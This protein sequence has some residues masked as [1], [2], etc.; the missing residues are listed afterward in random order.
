MSEQI[1]IA[2]DLGTTYFRVCVNR[3]DGF[4][5]IGN[6]RKRPSC[7]ACVGGNQWVVG[8]EAKSRAHENIKNTVD[9]FSSRR[10]MGQISRDVD[11]LK[12]Q[13]SEIKYKNGKTEVILKE[14]ETT[15]YPIDVTA[16]ILHEARKMAEEYLHNVVTKAV[17]TVPAC[18]NNVLRKGTSL[19]A[20]IA[21]FEVINVINDTL[22]AATYVYE[23]RMTLPNM[24]NLLVVTV[25]GGSYNVSV[26]S[27]KDGA[28]EE[29]RLVGSAEHGGQDI[30]A[31][32][33]DYYCQKINSAL[34]VGKIYPFIQEC[35]KAKEQLAHCN[36]TTFSAH[37]LDE[38]IIFRMT[39]EHLKEI[40]HSKTITSDIKAAIKTAMTSYEN[41]AIVL[42]GGSTHMKC[43]Q[44]CVPIDRVINLSTNIEEAVVRGAAYHAYKLHHGMKP[45]IEPTIKEHS[46]ITAEKK[47]PSVSWECIGNICHFMGILNEGDSKPS[48]SDQV[49]VS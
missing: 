9:L 44:E 21:G 48:E 49:M 17:I 34:E 8:E 41:I 37:N 39:T 29:H 47:S 4:H 5:I 28:F 19:A 10:S 43:I 23:R 18:F 1:A 13:L 6:E 42:I 26:I 30:D 24:K 38:E 3:G 11:E 22:A 32:L 7:I 20:T 25:G 35:I 33:I 27:P 40:P 14:G 2:I 36:V 46:D 12:H 15:I 45:F 16:M 31:E